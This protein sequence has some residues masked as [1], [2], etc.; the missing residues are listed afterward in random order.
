MV[1]KGLT[2]KTL[3]AGK[4]K[5]FGC[6]PKKAARFSYLGIALGLPS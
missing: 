2:K 1:E 5:V 3:F 6:S 4:K